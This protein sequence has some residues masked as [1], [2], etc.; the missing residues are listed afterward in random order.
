MNPYCRHIPCGADADF[1][2]LSEGATVDME[3]HAYGG[4]TGPDGEEIACPEEE[5][6]FRLLGWPW[7]PP[8]LRG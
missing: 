1:A 7:S 4:V 5:V 3:G 2:V 8:E 6:V